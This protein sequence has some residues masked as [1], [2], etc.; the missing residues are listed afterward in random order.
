MNRQ[1]RHKLFANVYEKNL[2]GKSKSGRKYNSDS[3]PELTKPYRDYVSNFIQQHSVKRAVDIGCG[4]FEA[5]SGIDMREAHYIGVD[6]CD[7]LIEYNIHHYGD[8]THEFLVCDIVEDDLPPGDLC[9]ITMVLY[10]LSFDEIFSVLRKLDQYRYVL[11]TDGQADIDPSARRNIDKKTD[12]YTRRDYYNNG[13][14]LEL[15]PFEL[16]LTVVCEYR[17]PSGEIIRTVLLESLKYASAL[18]GHREAMRSIA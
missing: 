9:L 8:E 17:I 14:Y 12:K 2:W 7:K 10:L 5:S 16:D 18:P 4:D 1:E 13:F 15:P 6:I 3:P 11:I